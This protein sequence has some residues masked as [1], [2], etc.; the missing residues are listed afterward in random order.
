MHTY[1]LGNTL[2]KEKKRRKKKS[3][4]FNENN[5]A[6]SQDKILN[7][8]VNFIVLLIAIEISK[9]PQKNVF[10]IIEIFHSLT[11]LVS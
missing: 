3:I 2:D 8:M 11:K 6:P 7:L 1:P 4:Q 5:K 9:L 10:S